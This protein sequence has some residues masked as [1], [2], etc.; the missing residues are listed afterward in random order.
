MIYLEFIEHTIGFVR[1][2][3]MPTGLHENCIHSAVLSSEIEVECTNNSA[4]KMHLY[5]KKGEIYRQTIFVTT[6]KKILNEL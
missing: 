2:A 3:L 6:G 1:L 4:T 5:L